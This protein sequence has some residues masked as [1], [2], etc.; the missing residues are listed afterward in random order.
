MHLL[1][2]RRAR[3][4]LCLHRDG[5]PSDLAEYSAFVVCTG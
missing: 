5:V 4:D 1:L 2:L 3:H